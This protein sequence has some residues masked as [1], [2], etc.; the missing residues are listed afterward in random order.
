MAIGVLR[1]AASVEHAPY[2]NDFAHYYLSARILLA[3][4]N[5]YETPL[6][7]LCREL[8]LEY[9]A[10]I[11]LGANPPLLILAVAAIA[12]LPLPTAYV[13]WGAMQAAALAVLLIAALRLL[14]LDKRS[15]FWLMSI[16]VVLNATCVQRHFHYSQV[17]L[18]VAA[19]LAW[20]LLL[21]IENRRAASCA[22]AT[23]AAAFKIYPAVLLPWFLLADLRSARDLFRRALAVLWVATVIVAAT[24]IDA[25]QSFFIDG[26][27]VINRSVGS[28]FTN[29]SL[30]ALTS[31]IAGALWG[32]P[33]SPEIAHAA[34]LIGSGL[35]A[36]ALAAAYL[37]VWRRRLPPIP[38]FGLLTA[39][40]MASS[41]V[42]WT[43]Y[44]VLMIVPIL[45]LWRECLT[46]HD[47]PIPTR[48]DLT[49]LSPRERARVRENRQ[50]GVPSILSTLGNRAMLRKAA[51]I[52]PF[53]AGA[54]CLYP[55]LDW[56]IPPSNDLARLALHYYPLAALA[57]V[58]LLLAKTP[59]ETRQGLA[60]FAQSSEQ[61]VPDP[62]RGR[63]SDRL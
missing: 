46:Q 53:A 28:S 12:W 58:A 61:I 3:G 14:A 45:W 2:R 24:G 56:P 62:V 16:G 48:S 22:L 43:H 17:Q 15:T 32:R 27:P 50:P 34:K 52:L 63:F 44:F 41:L 9:D 21:H 11:P 31:M 13:I 18:L 8:G 40:T 19:C 38:A 37:M 20:A 25:W 30:P 35:A 54:L 1:L 57:C 36:A 42:C 55:E 29:Y 47:A 23:L 5:P 59:P 26:L 49:S 6:A 60:Q 10:R 39:A 4:D 7:P 51:H 33:L